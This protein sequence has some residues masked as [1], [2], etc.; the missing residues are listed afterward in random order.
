MRV[1][2]ALALVLLGCERAPTTADRTTAAAN[3]RNVERA[4]S[5]PPG[6]PRPDDLPVLDAALSHFAADP[7]FEPMVVS[8]KNGRRLVVDRETTWGSVRAEQVRLDAPEGNLPQDALAD[9]EARNSGPAVAGPGTT[10]SGDGPAAA[11]LDGLRPSTPDV[12]VTDLSR[13]EG[14][15]PFGFDEALRKAYPDAQA[16][17]RAALPG[18]TAD[19]RRALVR[20]H[21]GPTP[22]G[23]S[24]TY[25]L[26]KHPAA[27]WKVTW[28]KLAYYA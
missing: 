17:A 20:I 10:T 14:D 24:G 5:K 28:R 3:E 18:Y 6:V 2:T 19:G 7:E 25:L 23:A 9:L 13:F 21:F 16:Y 8:F 11:P 4:P 26:E 12:V 1:V 22:H 27:G 15:E